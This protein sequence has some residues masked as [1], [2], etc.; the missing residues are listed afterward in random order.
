MKKFIHQI[1]LFT[2]SLIITLFFM[3]KIVSNGLQKTKSATFNNLNKI[4]NGE[5]NADLIIN[6]SSKALVQISP[7]ILDSI[8]KINSYNLGMD[9]TEFTPQL[10]QYQLYQKYNTKPKTII[11]IIG[12]TFLTKKKELYGYQKF[13]PYFYD[14]D[15]KE[16][17]KKYEGYSFSD[18]YIPFLRYSG[19]YSHIINGILNNFGIDLKQDTNYKGYFEQDRTW[20]DSFEK[21][22]NKNKNGIINKMDSL[23]KVDFERYIQNSLKNKIDIILVYP[24]TYIKSQKLIN[25]RGDIINYYQKIANKYDVP[26]LDYSNCYISN[27]TEFFYNSQHLNKKGAGIFTNILANELKVRAHNKVYNK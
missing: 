24:P 18:Y 16:L 10:L 7:I 27:S 1:I 23:S 11:Q 12:N 8:L 17:T 15:V 22:T 25:N 6:G 9:G 21:F 5:I 20:D 26:L 4:Y 14:K 19:M 3:D 13:A 2:I